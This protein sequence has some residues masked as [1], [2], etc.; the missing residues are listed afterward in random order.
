MSANSLCYWTAY[1]GL[2]IHIVKDIE[3]KK[4]RKTINHLELGILYLERIPSCR[5]GCKV[6][7]PMYSHL[8]V[9][10]TVS[11][12]RVGWLPLTVPICPTKKVQ[13]VQCFDTYSSEVS[14]YKKEGAV[15]GDDVIRSVITT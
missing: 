1:E 4:K 3:K 7:G 9:Y 12:V 13:N 10:I 11:F 5:R 6:D 8:Y 14:T 2:L 15:G